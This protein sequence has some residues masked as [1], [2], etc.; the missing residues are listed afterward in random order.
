MA[1]R[2]NYGAEKRQKEIQK[3]QKKEEKLEKKRLKKEAAA[4]GEIVE[5]DDELEGDEEDGAE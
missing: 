1:R 3:Q 5:G 2:P 4:N